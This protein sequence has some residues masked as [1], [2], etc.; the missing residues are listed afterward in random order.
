MQ[1]LILVMPVHHSEQQGPRELC[2]ISENTSWQGRV[3]NQD[4][5]AGMLTEARGAEGEKQGARRKNKDPTKHDERKTRWDLA[6]REPCD[7]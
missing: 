7:K 1:T 3:N 2:L 5:R 6:S 4:P